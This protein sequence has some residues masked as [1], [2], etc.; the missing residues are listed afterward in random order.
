MKKESFHKL[1]TLVA[2][3]GL[4]GLAPHAR[5]GEDTKK[6]EAKDM[7]EAMDLMSGSLK[8]LR[9]LRRDPDRW[10]KSAALVAESPGESLEQRQCRKMQ[11]AIIRS[12][13]FM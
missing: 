11:L 9:R 12:P 13:D 2:A 5:S 7:E 4:F 8:G 1:I 6:P 10:T 3:V